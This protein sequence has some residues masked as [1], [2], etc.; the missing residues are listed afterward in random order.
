VWYQDDADLQR[1]IFDREL[2]RRESNRTPR[3]RVDFNNLPAHTHIGD[4]ECPI[5]LSPLIGWG[6]RFPCGHVVCQECS[7]RVPICPFNCA[8]HHH[9]HE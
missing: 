8:N 9:D 2:R 6:Y 3:E 4:G 7:E 1:R 5:C